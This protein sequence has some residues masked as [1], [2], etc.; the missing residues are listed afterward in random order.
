[1]RT[2]FV[3]VSGAGTDAWYWHLLA[4]DLRSRGHLVATPEL[5]CDDDAAGLSAYAD[6]VTAVVDD[7]ARTVVVAHSFGGFTAP[8]VCGRA[9]IRRLVLLSA[10]VP[11]PGESA[12]EWWAATGYDR[13]RRRQD[14]ADGRPPDDEDA[15]FFHD[16]APE[17]AAQARAHDRRQSSTPYTEPWP[18]LAWPRT[19]TNFLLCRHDRFLP[20]AFMRGVVDE[21]LGLVP[22][23]IDGG[24]MVALSRPGQVADRL[25]AYAAMPAS[26]HA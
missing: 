26:D 17:L 11:R 3:F 19:P 4:D 1:M 8:L 6:V 10:M 12:A 13:A 23:E 25:A 24:H 9:P 22:D 21:R 2:A 18:L 14:E 7:P 15:L 16:V 20:A 5:P